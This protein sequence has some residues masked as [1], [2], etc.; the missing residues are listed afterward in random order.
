MLEDPNFY[1]A[2]IPAVLLVGLSKG[3]MG[4]A[5]TLMGVPILAMVVEPRVATALMLPILLVMDC[6]SLW[7]WRKHNDRRT[8][9]ELLPAGLIGVALGWITFAWV[10]S[11][12]MRLIIGVIAVAFSARFF[13]N[14]LVKRPEQ[15]PRPHSL[16]RG[17]FWGTLA[18]YGSF[19]AH[20]GGALWQIYTLP[21]KLDPKAY[22][23]ATVR[24][25]AIMNAVKLLPYWQLHLIDL[26]NLKVSAT[27][28]PF[29]PI[30][31]IAG[32]MM[33]KRMKV[34]T[35]YPFMYAMAGLAGLKL[36]Y[37]GIKPVLASLM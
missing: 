9:I 18:G 14:L 28:F 35:F 11:H 20:S 36:A 1:W 4:E 22:T 10:P 6:V 29:A 16:V 13:F 21:L 19:V 24:F 5:F 23:G 34:S 8:L 37:D 12:V 30:A 32:A 31:T 33:V 3:G 26:S 27:L 7:I 2:A 25:F 15:P 17:T